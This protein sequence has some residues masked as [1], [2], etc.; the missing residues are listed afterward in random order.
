MLASLRAVA[1]LVI[2]TSD[3][4]LPD[5]RQMIEARFSAGAGTMLSVALMSFAY[6]DGLPREADIVFDARFLRNPHYD[7]ALRPH[8]GLD[9]D[10]ADY[11]T[12]DPFFGGFYGHVLG[13]VQMVLPR[14]AQEGKKYVTIAVGCSGGRHRSVTVVEAL[15][16]D[17]AG[18][19]EIISLRAPI[20]VLHRELARKGLAA[21]RW[22]IPPDEAS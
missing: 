22:A 10:V 2:D 18:N 7:E 20:M 16:R 6:P 4:P 17:L 21:C 1:D 3:L 19:P 13:L 12:A 15:A 8:T 14:F 9:A 5:L 11:V